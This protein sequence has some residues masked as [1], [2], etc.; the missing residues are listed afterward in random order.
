MATM[1]E[2]QRPARGQHQLVADVGDGQEADQRQEQAEGDD[3]AVS[4]GVAAARAAS[5]RRGAASARR[6]PSQTFSTSGRPNR[7]C[8]RKISVIARTE[9]AA[10]SL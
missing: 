8:G 7:P 9:K 6:L 10:T 3:S 5:M 2:Q 1:R 4:A